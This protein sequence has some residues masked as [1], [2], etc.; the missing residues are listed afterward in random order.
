MMTEIMDNASAPEVKVEP[1]VAEA[2]VDFKTMLQDDLKG[3]KSLESFNDINSLV[4]SYIHQQHL[5]GKRVSELEGDEL[6]KVLNKVGKP[7]TADGYNLPVEGIDPAKVQGFK[8][9][10]FE[11]GLTQ[12]TAEKLFTDLII[13]ERQANEIKMKARQ[14]EDTKNLQ[15][16]KAE[17]GDAFDI[18]MKLAIDALEQFGEPGVLTQLEAAGLATNPAVIKLL[19]KAGMTLEEGK[20]LLPDRVEK[21]GLTPEDMKNRAKALMS[22]PAFFNRRHPDHEKTKKEVADL[23]GILRG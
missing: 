15:T 7:E 2:T 13:E 18:R 1:V 22:S 20:I 19:A 17:F 3:H 16:L 10:A 8:N 14:E 21:F 23:Y 9:K 4:K 6:E 5:I 11:A 12:K